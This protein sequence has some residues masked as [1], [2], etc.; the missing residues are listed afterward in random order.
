M[1]RK[2]GS[3][4]T[5]TRVIGRGT[6]GTVWEGTGPDGPVAVKLL[7]E[8]LAADQ[9]LIARFVQERTVLTSLAHP[10]VVAVRDLVVDGADLAL[11]MDL[12][13]G[14]DLRERLESGR[15]G[16]VQSGNAAG[17]AAAASF[18]LSDAGAESP[19]R[20]APTGG[21]PPAEAATLAADIAAGLAAAHAR[22]VVHRDVKPE[23][24]L[25]EAGSG[26]ARLT[27][28]GIARI[29]DGPRRTRATRIVGTPDYLAPEVIEGCPPGPPVDVYALGTL[30]FELLTGWTPFGGGHPGAVLRRHVTETPPEIPG[31]PEPLA[32]I[33]RACLSK[34]PAARLTAA[35]VAG[36]LRILVPDLAGLPAL[37]VADPRTAIDPAHSGTSNGA[38]RPV[39]MT[40]G[41]VPLVNVAADAAD[42]SRSTHMNLMRPI[43]E[44]LGPSAPVPGVP[45]AD[46]SRS[47][48]DSDEEALGEADRS[49]SDGRTSRRRG[50]AALAAV[51]VVA[52][53]AAGGYV[54]WHYHR[55]HP[56]GLSVGSARSADA[57]SGGSTSAAPPSAAAGERSVAVGPLG[58]VTFGTVAAPEAGP[59]GAVHVAAA[60]NALLLAMTGT[61]G[62]VRYA[63]APAVSGTA[64]FGQPPQF[65][66]WHTLPGVSSAAEPALVGRTSGDAE[67]YVVSSA[68]SQIHRAVYDPATATWSSWSALAGTGT[69]RVAGAPAALALD[70]GRTELL[71]A[72]AAGS[73]LTTSS[74][75]G[76]AGA[77]W[78][79]WHAIS[80]AGSV[81]PGVALT[82]RADGAQAAFAVRASDQAVL[83]LL[84]AGASPY[85]W[86]PA[87]S[88]GAVGQP[89]ASFV[90][91][92][93][94]D[95]FVRS[96][97]GDVQVY[98]LSGA[99][100]HSPRTAAS[101]G[102]TSRNPPGVAVTLPDQRLILAVTADDGSVRLYAETV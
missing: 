42:D 97:S 55:S 5:V 35:E 83:S 96:A 1:T 32:E 64:A 51:I 48:V 47:D 84:N 87:Y 61:D 37:R 95:L 73:L 2:I 41:S 76:A 82:A 92:G 22:G 25:I 50:F 75:S 40:V 23:N 70:G 12:V 34:A 19:L 60:G 54:W 46:R 101:A 65:G 67:L 63:V 52:L 26:T 86:G 16:T 90:A 10:N 58:L 20:A 59:V 30:M 85:A 3:R 94:P 31:M 49:P 74:G 13:S 71:V 43:R 24:V 78:Q 100:A 33:L 15:I 69:T 11:V 79:T 62:T 18:S 14:T 88:T 68:D 80:A 56:A 39:P 36:R 8:D 29:V 93:A 81:K 28:F 17:L 9:T 38:G 77:A 72:S 4:Y 98:V 44:P 7:R 89:E 102:V 45:S 6:C 57:L 66:V 27:D 53:V 91:N 21:L 99:N